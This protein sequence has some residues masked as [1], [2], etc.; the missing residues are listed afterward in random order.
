V[1]THE[2]E[3]TTEVEE[4]LKDGHVDAKEQRTIDHLRHE[5]SLTEEHA[6]AIVQQILEE[7]SRLNTQR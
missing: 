7:K 4:L 1:R 5:Y 2:L 6:R 3:F